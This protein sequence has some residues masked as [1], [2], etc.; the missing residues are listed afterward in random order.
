MLE[1]YHVM[2]LQDFLSS[3][4]FHIEDESKIDEINI[5]VR[6]R[7]ESSLLSPRGVRPIPVRTPMA[8]HSCPKCV[9]CRLMG[10]RM[11]LGS[12]IGCPIGVRTALGSES[13]C[14]MGVRVA[15]GQ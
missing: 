3:R 11:A 15:L 14:P 8:I 2:K 5:E 12:E 7:I 9:T 1:S 10:V 13:S 6:D 4:K